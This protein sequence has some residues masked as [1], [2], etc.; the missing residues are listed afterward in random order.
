[1]QTYIF[2]KYP[3]IA[4]EISDDSYYNYKKNI[5]TKMLKMRHE[6]I[7]EVNK[8]SSYKMINVVQREDFNNNDLESD[9]NL[10]AKAKNDV[11]LML[12]RRIKVIEDEMIKLNRHLKDFVSCVDLEYAKF[13]G[14]VT[15][16]HMAQ[17][18]LKSYSFKNP[19]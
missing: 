2:E 15:S 1:M 13:V 17:N 6:H 16:L 11:N 9:M 10:T 3:E 7:E 18:R 5:M 4:A 19:A 12:Q 8:I 14:N